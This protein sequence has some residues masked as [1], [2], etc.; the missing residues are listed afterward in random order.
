MF[1]CKYK[2]LSNRS[3]GIFFYQWSSLIITL[4]LDIFTLT[5]EYLAVCSHYM[6]Y[7][8]IMYLF[9]SGNFHDVTIIFRKKS[10]LSYKLY[11]FSYFRKF[12]DFLA[13]AAFITVVIHVVFI[14]YSYY[15][16]IYGDCV[17]YVQRLID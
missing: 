12:I 7:L 13:V 11:K 2:Y 14:I 10:I 16:V 6:N 1:M 3:H 5:L 9:L 17:I 8:I 4:Q 15:A